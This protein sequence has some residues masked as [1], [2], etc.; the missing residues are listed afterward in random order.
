[1]A[2]PSI[3]S[4]SSYDG[5]GQP[6]DLAFVGGIDLRHG[7]RDDARHEGDPQAPPLD[8]RYRA[9]SSLARRAAS[10]PT[11]RS[12]G[13]L[14][15]PAANRPRWLGSGPHVVRIVFLKGHEC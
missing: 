7:R 15:Q 6:Q 14:P 5:G 1:M 3:K 9:A 8:K 11:S 13:R 4:W 2:A 10:S 12:H